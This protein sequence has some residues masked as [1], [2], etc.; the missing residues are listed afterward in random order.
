MRT[1]ED[2]LTVH[3]RSHKLTP[4]QCEVLSQTTLRKSTHLLAEEHVCTGGPLGCVLVLHLLD[5]LLLNFLD[6][7]L[8]DLLHLGWKRATAVSIM[9][10]DCL[11]EAGQ[12]DQDMYVAH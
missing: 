12:Q 9:M 6:L 2:V 7:L 3:T 4:G 11:I 10:I 8:L 5:L 1:K